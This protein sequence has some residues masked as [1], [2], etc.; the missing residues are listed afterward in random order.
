MK[1]LKITKYGGPEVLET[2]EKE[3]EKPGPG[4]IT[5]EIHYAGINP[6]DT[7]LC[8]GK[9]GYEPPL[10]FTPG[11][12]GAGVVLQCGP[13]VSSV[14]PGDRVFVAWSRTGTC[15]GQCLAGENQVFKLPP[16]LDL[17]QG[18]ALF[19]NYFTAWRALVVRGGL[20]PG[21]RVLIHGASG[22]VGM[23]AL[24]W[25]R[26][27]A[28]P[29]WG[30]AG[31]SDGLALVRKQGAVEAGD[32]TSLD[33]L[34]VLKKSS[35]GFD[36]IVEML[37]DKNLNEDLKLL[38]RNGR[39]VIV[40]SRGTVEI[41]PRLTMGVETDIR[42]VTLK[43]STDADNIRCLKDLD[44]AVAKGIINPVIQNIYPL[45]QADKAYRE[46]MEERS[47]GK[48]LLDCSSSY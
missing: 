8:A 31:S 19:L 28:N 34:D 17:K 44:A 47:R 5:L 22:G 10:P 20:K 45:E 32:H 40:G 1:Y 29:V 2:S 46:L 6:V 18:A 41:N 15:A 26:F 39:V 3:L 13:D 23:A 42:G 25:C 36:L 48:I 7:Y 37:A 9:N 12:E 43:N 4:E 16:S 21:D 35:G 11:V 14:V 27:F 33:Y 30:T 38:D 24:Q